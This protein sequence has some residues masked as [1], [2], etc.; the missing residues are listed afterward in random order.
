M[1]LTADPYTEKEGVPIAVPRYIRRSSQKNQNKT[2]AV[3]RY[4]LKQALYKH[5]I[6]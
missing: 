5:K 4:S 2:T 6:Y 3:D 1:N